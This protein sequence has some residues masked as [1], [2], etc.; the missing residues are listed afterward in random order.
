MGVDA[1]WLGSLARDDYPVVGTS[2]DHAYKSDGYQCVCD[3]RVGNSRD[4]NNSNR[5]WRSVAHY[6]YEQLAGGAEVFDAWV[7]FSLLGGTANGYWLGVYDSYDAWGYGGGDSDLLAAGTPGSGGT[8]GGAALAERYESSAKAGN[9]GLD[10]K[11]IGQ[12]TPGLYTYK[13]FSTSL[14]VVYDKAPPSPSPSTPANG[15]VAVSTTPS[16]V[17]SPVA[18]PDGDPV[19]YW[20]RVSTNSDG[21]SGQVWNTGWQSQASALVPSGVLGDAQTYW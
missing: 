16:L 10:L 6:P 19:Y 9:F 8:V 15:A 18:D 13:R 7:N 4:N 3:I 17:V 11:L 12:Q 20:F 5:Y 14:S 21:E 2:P 1:G